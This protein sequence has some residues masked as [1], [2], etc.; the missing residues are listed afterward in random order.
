MHK[1]EEG[2]VTVIVAIENRDDTSDQWVVSELRDLE[3]L[4]RLE[5]ATLISINLAEI[6]VELLQLSL[7]EV[8]V[9]EL[10]LLLCKLVSHLIT[11]NL[12]NNL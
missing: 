1:F 5:G 3:E 2:D 9:L 12:K 7:R 8:E 10:L 4:R 6:L 11:F